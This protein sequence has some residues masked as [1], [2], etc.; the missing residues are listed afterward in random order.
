MRTKLA[1]LVVL[2]VA[3]V[4]G[5]GGGGKNHPSV[6]NAQFSVSWPARSRDN[7][8]V[9]LSSALSAKIVFTGAGKSGQDVTV[10]IDRDATNL[11]AY[12]GTY[13]VPTSIEVSRLKNLT[14][15]FYSA[16]GQTGSVVGTATST[17]TFSGST[18]V[19]TPISL[20]GTIATVTATPATLVPG[21]SAT[22]LTFTAKTA[23]DVVVAVSPGSATWTL[24]EGSDVISLTPDGLATPL[25]AGTA[26][27]TVTVDGKTSEHAI[28]TV[29]APTVTAFTW[30]N[31]KGGTLISP[32]FDAVEGNQIKILGTK[33]VI[34]TKLGYE[35]KS[36][37][38]VNG[39]TA[40]YDINGNVL[41][42]ATIGTS[43][44]LSDG[45]YYKEITPLTLKAGV[46]YYI[47]S[48]HGTGD[49]ASYYYA[50][51]EAVTPDFIQ[52]VGATFKITSTIDGGTWEPVS[53]KGHYISNFIAH[54][55]P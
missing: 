31:G 1:L 39:I 52:E 40:I 51:N 43:D 32:S 49:D 8:V 25:A 54:Q 26:H 27:V 37:T 46:T 53:G 2:L 38:Q 41:A 19:F 12:T 48:L 11:A 44:T 30:A 35:Y 22:Q 16:A 4:A 55:A 28:I 29:S 15:T 18:L 13:T 33:D 17:A 42:Q 10:N 34:V 21:G 47:G 36:A 7:I 20:T 45:Y 14:A 24:V 6:S 23:G 3:F 9:N 5:C 50:A